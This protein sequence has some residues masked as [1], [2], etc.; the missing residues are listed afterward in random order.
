MLSFQLNKKVIIAS[1]IAIATLFGSTL[2]AA[3]Q[4][5]CD[6]RVFNIKVND[7]V[8]IDEM[9][10]QLSD[11]CHFSVVIKDPEAS[12]V[13]SQ[14]LQGVNIKDMSLYEVFDLLLK[15]NNLNYEYKKNLLKVS[16]LM[17]K[18]FRLD[19]ITSVRQGTA[20]LNASVSATPTEEGND[21]NTDDKTD[22]EIK[23]TEEFDF[24]KTIDAEIKAILN[25]GTEKYV[26]KDPIINQ[27]AGLITITGT[28]QQ[29]D[30]VESYLMDME[31]RLHK[32]VLIDVSIIS[33]ALTNSESTGIDWSKFKLNINTSATDDS[34][35]GSPSTATFTNTIDDTVN[36]FSKSVSIVNS[37]EF[38]MEGVLNF[39]KEKGNTKVISNPKVITLNNQQALITVGENI[40]YR[41]PEE[42]SDGDT[43]ENTVTYNNYSIFIG[44]LLNLLPEISEDNEIMLRINPSLSSFKYAVDDTGYDPT[45][46]PR[47]IAP[48]TTEKKLSTVVQ[49]N[50]GDTI[51]LGG[52]IE[53]T[54][55]KENSSVPVLSEL[56]IL[57][58]AFRSS[59]D[60]VNT[61]ELIFII[62]PRII[63]KEGTTKKSLKDLG[64]SESLYE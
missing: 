6:Y 2:N 25:N 10:T 35:N 15:E 33:V 1:C 64:Y 8:A 23:V 17:T 57:G 59:T 36:T 61:S 54:K 18:T 14:K 50:S 4:K 42:T 37:L 7:T 24:W 9:L 5:S 55:G 19:Y 56:P 20:T 28:K 48:D 30:R 62:T 44:V 26:T 32:Q 46:N 52:L 43:N 29:L 27:Q 31:K 34:S 60:T 47:Q 53:N 40:N 11:L 39:L 3:T 22:N 21:R 13:L 38:S 41:V 16:A 12:T 45:G 63:G 58:S 51:I 49:V